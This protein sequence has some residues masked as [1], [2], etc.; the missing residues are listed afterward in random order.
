MLFRS[1]YGS[2]KM[3]LVGLSNVLA[4]EGAKYGI[5]SNV[6]APLAATRLSQG[7]MGPAADLLDPECVTPMVVYLASEECSL[8]HEIFSAGGG[9]FARVFVGLT[10]GFVGLYQINVTIPATVE[11]GPNVPVFLN[12][13]NNIFSNTVELAIE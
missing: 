11:K 2:A 12:M 13:G 6:I 1:N 5:L 4:I 7:V 3:G 8:T 10:P 9:R